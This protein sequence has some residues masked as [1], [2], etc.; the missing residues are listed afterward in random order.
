MGPYTLVSSAISDAKR[1]PATASVIYLFSFFVIPASV[2]S[3]RARALQQSSDTLTAAAAAN[4]QTLLTNGNLVASVAAS[5]L[6]PALGYSSA[7]AL[8]NAITAPPPQFSLPSPSPSA[9]AAPSDPPA[10]ADASASSL[11]WP[12]VGG[13]VGGGLLAA[14]AVVCIVRTVRARAR[15]A[16]DAREEHIKAAARVAPDVGVKIRELD[17]VTPRVAAAAAGKDCSGSDDV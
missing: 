16:R 13:A 12:I 2:T 6:A 1:N 14:L 15:A 8:L 17:D 9:S 11:L 4:V 5:G 3:G 7:D 10:P